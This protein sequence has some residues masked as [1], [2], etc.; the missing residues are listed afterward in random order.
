MIEQFKEKL[1]SKF[2][3]NVTFWSAVE[4]YIEYR[5]KVIKKPLTKHAV[6][7]ICNKFNK[8][9]EVG[10]CTK[11]LFDSMEKGYIGVFPSDK[12]TIS[13]EHSLLEL[14]ESLHGR[15]GN[16]KIEGVYWYGKSFEEIFK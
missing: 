13:K 7:L 8:R 16:F 1:L 3:G 9:D 12:K 15:F 6:T 11:A 10:E 5:E 14:L 4:D 2:Q